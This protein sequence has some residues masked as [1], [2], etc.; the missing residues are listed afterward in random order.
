MDVVVVMVMVLWWSNGEKT[1]TDSNNYFYSL[2]SHMLTLS[3][4]S[5]CWNNM[6]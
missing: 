3:P 1:R 6:P 5:F 2:Y 4:D